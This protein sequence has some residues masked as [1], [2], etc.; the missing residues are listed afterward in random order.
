MVRYIWYYVQK[1]PHKK[2]G[3]DMRIAVVD[4]EP[5]CRANLVSAL[6]TQYQNVQI[7]EYDDGT[8]AWQAIQQDNRFD[9]VITDM[10]MI[11]MDGLEL[12]KK[13]HEKY[14]EIQILYQT[15]EL[16]KKIKQMGVQTERC[17]FKPVDGLELKQKLDNL[18]ALPP[19]EIKP[20]QQ[21]KEEP[22]IKS[23]PHKERRGFFSRLFKTKGKRAYE[24]A[25]F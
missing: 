11:T 24:Q 5:L 23:P 7:E 8:P 2:D 22:V 12:S 17:L 14:P 13:I 6:C 21:E 25:I 20:K 1:K 9:L 15:G 16:E 3:G 18:S 10:S 4:D 19:F